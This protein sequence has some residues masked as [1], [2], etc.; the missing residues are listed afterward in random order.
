MVVRKLVGLFRLWVIRVRLCNCS[1][2]MIEVI[3]LVVWVSV[4]GV[5]SWLLSL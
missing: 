1:V 5:E 2:L 4:G 3:V